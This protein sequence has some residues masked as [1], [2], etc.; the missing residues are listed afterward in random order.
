[1]GFGWEYFRS[2]S[3]GTADPATVN[4]AGLSETGAAACV[5]GCS[6]SP[7]MS[8]VLGWDSGM[9]FQSGVF[10]AGRRPDLDPPLPEQGAR[11]IQL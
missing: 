7:F 2:H 11:P 8:M 4:P 5:A 1:M 3:T 9:H 10:G 6:R